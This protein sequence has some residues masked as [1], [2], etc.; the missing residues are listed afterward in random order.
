MDKFKVTELNLY[1]DAF[2]ALKKYQHCAAPSGRLPLFHWAFGLRQ[3]TF[4]KT[5]N[6]MND[7]VE[8]CRQWRAG[9]YWTARTFIGDMDVNLLRKAGG[10]GISKAQPFSHEYL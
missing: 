6:R 8:G 5:L 10:H 9:C 4:F 1:Y 7:L 2:Q 3:V